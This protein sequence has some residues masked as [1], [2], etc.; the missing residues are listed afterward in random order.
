MTSKTNVFNPEKERPE[1]DYPCTW[2]YKVIGKDK[3]LLEKAI[4]DICAPTPV[5]ISFSNASSSGKYFSLNAELTV[6][7][8]PMR[9]TLFA[10]F[11]NHS[12][13]TMVI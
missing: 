8:E 11:Q 6:Q 5:T 13:V 12:D 9:D 2:Q 1:I 4:H 7:D 3:Y 10:A